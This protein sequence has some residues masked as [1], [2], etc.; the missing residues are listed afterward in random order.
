[1]E[2]SY[3]ETLKEQESVVEMAFS[4]PPLCISCCPVNGV[5]VGCNNKLVMFCL[6]Y[7]VVNQNL[8]VLDFECSL[9]LY[10]DNFIPAE[11][12]FYAGHIAI[13]TKLDIL[14]LKLD[15]VQ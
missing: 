14:I 12:A 2:E 6:K 4:D 11:V 8:T 7:L 1:M 15:L 10:I 5:L 3:T 13:T 9:I